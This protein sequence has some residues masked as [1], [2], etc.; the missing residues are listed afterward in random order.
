LKTVYLFFRQRWVETILAL[1]MLLAYREWIFGTG[2][3]V[4]GDFPFHFR[5]LLRESFSIQSM[6]ANYMDFGQVTVLASS[7][8]TKLALGFLASFFD[9]GVAERAVYFWPILILSYSGVLLLGRKVF[10]KDN[11]GLFFFSVLFL[12]NTYILSIQTSFVSYAA[13]Y[14]MTPLVFYLVIRLL[15][16]QRFALSQAILASLSIATAYIYE[17]RAGVALTYFLLLYL[18]FRLA[19]DQK[20]RAVRILNFGSAYAILA[21]LTVFS[22]IPLRFVTSDDLPTTTALFVAYN[23]ILDALAFHSYAWQ[24]DVSKPF[25]NTPFQQVAASAYFYIVTITTFV[26]GIFIRH[27]RKKWL[28]AFLLCASLLG[29][30]LLKQQNPPLGEIYKLAFERLPTF[31]LFRESNKFVLFLLPVSILFGM[32]VSYVASRITNAWARTTLL[33]AL[34]L[35]VMVNIKPL[36]TQEI[37]S[38]FIAREIPHDYAVVQE[39]IS[40]QPDFFRTY[41]IPR[42][43]RWS[44]RTGNHPDISAYNAIRSNWKN[45]FS[46]NLHDQRLTSEQRTQNTLGANFMQSLLKSASAKYVLLQA[47]DTKNNETPYNNVEY[48]SYLDLLARTPW[49]KKVDIGTKNVIVFE[50]LQFNKYISTAESLVELGSLRNMEDTYA[51]ISSEFGTGF[52]AT[53]GGG[54]VPGTVVKD[55]FGDVRHEDVESGV[56]DAQQRNSTTGQSIYINAH[57]ADIS[58]QLS[59]HRLSFY[60]TDHDGL[61][62]DGKRAT[63]MQP[64]KLVYQVDVDSDKS[65]WISSGSSLIPIDIHD[66]R[67]RNLGLATNAIKVYNDASRNRVQNPSLEEGLWEAKARDCN[68]YDEGGHIDMGI[69]HDKPNDG[70]N[71]LTLTAIQHIAC[72]GPKPVDVRPGGE[73]RLG[74][75]YR[76]RQGKEA[77]YR[78][79]FNDPKKTTT[80]AYFPSYGQNWQ[81]VS[82]LVSA[83]PGATR[84][85]VELE[86]FPNEQEPIEGITDYDSIQLTALNLI[87]TVPVPSYVY[88]QLTIPSGATIRYAEPGYTYNNLFVNGSLEK[89][90]WR[91]KVGDCNAYNNH[92][93]L[94]MRLSSEHADGKTSLQLEASR[95]TACSGPDA[96]NVNENASY[97]LNFD[98]QSP[99]SD[100]A[101]YHIAFDDPAGTT[102]TERLPIKDSKWNTFTKTLKVPYGANHMSLVVYAEESGGKTIINRYD[103]FRIMEIPDIANKYY[104]V[105]EAPRKLQKP[106]DLSYQA[107][108]PTKKLVHIKGASTPFYLAM[109]EAYQPQWR[110]EINNQ[111]VVGPVN[112]WVP[113]VS[114]NAVVANDHFKLDDFLNGWYVDVDEFC[115][116]QH[117]C[118]QNADGSYDMELVAEFAP[119]RWFYIGGIISSA[120]LLGCIGYLVW[121]WRRRWRLWVSLGQDAKKI[122]LYPEPREQVKPRNRPRRR[123]VRLG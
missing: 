41:W 24:G 68:P 90:L 29:V 21:L 10:G 1:L 5:D 19:Q 92:A 91:A 87:A 123:K 42:P 107:L 89:G 23:T 3:L 15:D 35:V 112:N 117:L 80:R 45:L 62:V 118:R 14:A 44:Y 43:S 58:Y 61:L 73:L 77:G 11:V 60:R 83:P 56:I 84:A 102:T 75:S 105:A 39:F 38:L 82:Q 32:S 108:S 113:W 116:K 2:Y 104:L 99:N 34:G 86:A 119:Q 26:S 8:P 115:H 37:R 22:A 97:L 54:K 53:E 70:K 49:L 100:H 85:R 95:H 13:A 76:T 64:R 121:R 120:A 59:G 57:K 71:I 79:V 33:C 27:F 109:S 96:I 65:Y 17:P 6:W 110:L 101:N 36:L 12:F 18:A 47:S 31:S 25:Y 122:S 30:F 114:P 66:L 7:A 88:Q 4:G 94:G 78:L 46:E 106:K 50:N 16:E 74:L 40:R 69:T 9:F 67:V 103:N 63:P 48:Q 111:R 52:N 20:A 98:Y 55:L 28:A 81:T 93:D 72:S 51:L